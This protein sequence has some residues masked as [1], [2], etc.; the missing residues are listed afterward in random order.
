VPLVH[1]PINNQ[2]FRSGTDN[3]RQ[4]IR[5][6][7]LESSEDNGCL[8]KRRFAHRIRANDAGN[9]RIE[10]QLKSRETAKIPYGK[11]T[12]HLKKGTRRTRMK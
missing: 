1:H 2:S 10:L 12:K 9:L 3:W 11:I 7:R 5:S 6:G 4:R 8:Q